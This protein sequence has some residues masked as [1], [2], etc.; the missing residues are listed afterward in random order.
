[1]PWLNSTQLLLDVA[2]VD[3]CN[4]SYESATE[5]PVYLAEQRKVNKYQPF[6]SE[7]NKS[8]IKRYIFCP[9]GI[10]IYGRIGK[11]GLKFIDEFQLFVKE[12]YNK[13]VNVSYWTN[14][15]VFSCFKA[16]PIMIN[17]A[18]RFLGSHYDSLNGMPLTIDGA[19]EVEW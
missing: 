13:K 15:I 19:A 10:S 14:R 6:L 11:H 5:C 18:L 4:S 17:R 12:Q 3:P 1:M 8:Q 7:L 16:T 2:T 9:F